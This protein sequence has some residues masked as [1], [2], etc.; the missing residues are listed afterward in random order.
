MPSRPVWSLLVLIVAGGPN[1]AA[2]ADGFPSHRSFCFWGMVLQMTDP[3]AHHELQAPVPE[4]AHDFGW[5]TL[6]SESVDWV[7]LVEMP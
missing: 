3:D 7:G 4:T 2:Y 1:P 6:L 5:E